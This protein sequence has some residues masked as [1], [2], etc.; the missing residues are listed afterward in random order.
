MYDV[1]TITFWK[2]DTIVRQ[3]GVS[4]YLKYTGYNC[5]RLKRGPVTSRRR[6]ED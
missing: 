5:V 3:R 2:V 4:V 6:L 1:E